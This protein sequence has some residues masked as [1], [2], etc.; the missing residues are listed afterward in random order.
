M[1]EVLFGT[2]A[3][4]TPVTLNPDGLAQLMSTFQLVERL[5]TKVPVIPVAVFLVPPLVPLVRLR[6]GLSV[7]E[8]FTLRFAVIERTPV[9]G[10]VIDVLAA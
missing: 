10:P 5:W 9:F 6:A 3:I 1:K 4:A 7:A 8:R 2:L